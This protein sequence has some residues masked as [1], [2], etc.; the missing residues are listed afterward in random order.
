LALTVGEG[1]AVGEGL[2]AGLGLFAALPVSPLDDAD[3]D[4]LGA[5]CK[6]E[7]LTGSSVPQPAAKAIESLI[8]SRSAVRLS[9]FMFGVL[10]IFVPRSNRIEKARR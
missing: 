2:T 7:L 6:F 10:I 8:K 1:D 4:G 5:A 3:A 9:M